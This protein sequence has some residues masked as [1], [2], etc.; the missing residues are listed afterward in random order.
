MA[1]IDLSIN[2][3]VA[4]RILT[5]FIHSEVTRVGFQRAVLGLS[6][7]LD[8][9]LCCYLAAEALGPENIL[10]IRN[11]YKTSSQDSYEHAQLVIDALGVQ[12]KTIDITPI[13]D[14]FF[15]AIP[16]M[17]QVRQGNVMARA[18]MITWFD[19]SAAFKG[20]VLGTGNKTE[21]LLG[22]TTIFGDAAYA[23]N[24]NGDLYKTQLRQLAKAVG[25]PQVILDKPPSAD[26]WAGQTDEGELGF[27]Y[28]EVDKLLYLLVDRRYTAEECVAAGFKTA[29]VQTV[30]ERVRRNHF[31][32]T[33]PL[34]AKLSNR[35]VGY[36]FLYLRDWGT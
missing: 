25:V 30:I 29:F 5:G 15:A 17:D 10:A 9:A 13:V 7:G 31:K 28:A 26:L 34:I 4:R 27:T 22:Y 11:P 1:A 14:P 20:L 36:D 18:R 16:D 3:T 6:G 33:L 23:L 12:E 35:T 32:R 24:P 21:I 8:S 2:T 19:Q